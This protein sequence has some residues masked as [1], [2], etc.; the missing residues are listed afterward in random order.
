[1]NLHI[2]GSG[3]ILQEGSNNNCSGYLLDN[4]LLFDCGPGIWK[5]IQQN[6][7]KLQDLNHI[8]ISHFHIDH[9]SDLSPILLNRYLL[10]DLLKKTLNITGP[11]GLTAWFQHLISLN[12]SWISNMSIRLIEM[13][14]SPL[15][16]EGYE[17]LSAN[18]GH[19]EN[20]L[21]YRVEKEGKSFFYSG[22]TDYNQDI[23]RMAKS[24]EL[25]IIEASNTEATLIEGHMTPQSAIRIATNAKVKK[26][27]LTHMYPEVLHSVDTIIN[28][29]KY[30][31]DLIIAEDGLK[32]D[33]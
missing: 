31:F 2:L 1:M 7:V 8:F 22:D 3:T 18:T 19:T 16:I 12:G 10:P 27:L 32:I 21:C 14:N 29:N 4:K 30:D 13:E 20:S 24:A 23:T 26:L 11:Q 5:S 9:T 17:I 25:A 6:Q 15:L 33:F 28:Q